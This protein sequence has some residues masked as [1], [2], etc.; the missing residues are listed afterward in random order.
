MQTDFPRVCLRRK[1]SSVVRDTF[2]DITNKGGERN[3]VRRDKR[4][5]PHGEIRNRRQR[6]MPKGWERIRSSL[7]KQWQKRRPGAASGFVGHSTFL[8]TAVHPLTNSLALKGSMCVRSPGVGSRTRL[9]STDNR[10]MTCH[11]KSSLRDLMR[12]FKTGT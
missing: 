11:L 10:P 12:E 5:T 2:S 8:V 3:K 9:P 4:T 7:P 1:K 6:R